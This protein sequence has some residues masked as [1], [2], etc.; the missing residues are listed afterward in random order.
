M[1]ETVLRYRKRVVASRTTLKIGRSGRWGESQEAEG[2]DGQNGGARR[3][4][5]V[6]A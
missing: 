6:E 1:R 2:G 5:R 3:H 4:S